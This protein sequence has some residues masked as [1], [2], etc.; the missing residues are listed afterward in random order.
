[1]AACGGRLE[2][3]LNRLK[4]PF[5]CVILHGHSLLTAAEAV[6]V[7]RRCDVV[8]LCTLNRETRL[9]MVKKA[10]ERIATMEIPFSGIVYLGATPQEALC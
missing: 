10:S 8:L 5:D 6:E 9:P 1:M 2:A 4:E 3:L 7:S